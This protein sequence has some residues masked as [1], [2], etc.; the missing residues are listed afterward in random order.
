MNMSTNYQPGGLICV[1]PWVAHIN[2]V[3]FQWCHQWDSG[4]QT[5]HSVSCH[6]RYTVV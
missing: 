2:D 1:K 6:G 5:A 3:L 4:F